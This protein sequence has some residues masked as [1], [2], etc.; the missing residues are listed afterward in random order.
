[1]IA[2]P[3]FNMEPENDGFQQESPFPEVYFEVPC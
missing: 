3:K 1:M 2:P